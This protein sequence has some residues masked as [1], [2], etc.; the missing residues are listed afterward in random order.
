M[1]SSQG[2][3]DFLLDQLA[4]AGEVSARKMFGEYGLYCDG[5]LVGSICDD[6]LY[7][8][9]TAVGRA[10]VGCVVEASPYPG[11]KPCLLIPGDRWEDAHWLADIVRATA[12]ALPAPTR[13][14]RTRT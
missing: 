13:A 5:R 7:L 12:A 11:A 6:Q 14:R 10:R 8:K 4:A 9:P 2:T 1:A 3:V